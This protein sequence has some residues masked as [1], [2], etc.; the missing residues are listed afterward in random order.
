MPNTN[1]HELAQ[2]PATDAV[3]ASISARPPAVIVLLSVLY[4][5]FF[6]VMLA[7]AYTG[8]LPVAELSKINNFDKIG[9]V[10][11]YFI[12]TYLGHRLCRGK[13][14]RRAIPVFPSLFALF[15]IAEELVQGL[16]PNRT[17][18]AGDMVCSLVGVAMG[19]WLAQ[20]QLKRSVDGR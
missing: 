1:S 4:C 18:D 20:R 12:P 6:L 5:T 14:V 11:L 2:R 17:L 8:D 9:H 19:Y 3:S 15:T 13:H 10:I 16:S 7:A